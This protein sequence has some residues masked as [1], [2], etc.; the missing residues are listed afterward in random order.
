[1]IKDFSCQ[2]DIKITV[3]V[4][5]KIR[6]INIAEIVCIKELLLNKLT[7]IQARYYNS[8]PL[9]GMESIYCISITKI[10]LPLIHSIIN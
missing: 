3:K 4:G 8:I 9:I 6:L 2:R 7:I 1:M 5:R 10:K